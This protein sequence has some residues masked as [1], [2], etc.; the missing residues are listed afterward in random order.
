MTVFVIVALSNLKT[1]VFSE[2]KLNGKCLVG[3]I[4]ANMI[5]EF[6]LIENRNNSY[7]LLSIN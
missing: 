2:V 4:C 3:Y 5:T 7:L 6:F 1:S